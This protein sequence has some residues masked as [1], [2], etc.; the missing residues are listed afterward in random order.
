M[1]LGSRARSRGDPPAGGTISSPP[2]PTWLV[3]GHPEFRAIVINEVADKED[4]TDICAG[5]DW[6]EL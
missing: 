6:V 4:D 2:P 5:V 1:T 3:P